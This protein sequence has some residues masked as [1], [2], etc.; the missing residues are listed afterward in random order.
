MSSTVCQRSANMALVSPQ[1]SALVNPLLP[2]LVFSLRPTRPKLNLSLRPPPW[3]PAFGL[4][5]SNC[6]AALHFG[7]SQ[8][9]RGPDARQDFASTAKAARQPSALV[10]PTVNMPPVA[11]KL[12]AYMAQEIPQPSTLTYPMAVMPPAGCKPSAY[13]DQSALQPSVPPL[14]VS[15]EPIKP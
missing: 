4:Y 7:Q 1:P 13:T 9:P 11:S 8:G 3:C 15:I 14:V 12:S 10:D 5:S 2:S 6:S